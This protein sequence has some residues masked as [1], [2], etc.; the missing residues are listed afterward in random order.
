M[1]NPIQKREKVIAVI[2]YKRRLKMA[3]EQIKSTEIQ[4]S[5]N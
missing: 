1:K 4:G 3:N 5:E 2:L